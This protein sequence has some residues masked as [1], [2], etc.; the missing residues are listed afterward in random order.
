[1]LIFLIAVLSLVYLLVYKPA[2]R[3]AAGLN[4]PLATAWTALARDPYGALGEDA[5]GRIDLGTLRM[6]LSQAE[7]LSAGFVALSNQLQRRIEPSPEVKARMLSPFQLVAY[8]NERQLKLEQLQAHART[9]QVGLAQTTVSNWFPEHSA[10]LRNPAL[11]WGQLWM[12]DALAR[13]A[14]AC[15]VSEIRQISP[16][17]VVSRV[18]TNDP[19]VSIEEVPIAAEMIGSASS[20]AHFL[21]SLPLKDEEIAAAGL[22][23]GGTNKPVLFIEKVLV[24]KHSPEQADQVNLELK[25]RGVLLRQLPASAP[26]SVPSS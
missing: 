6:R 16:G 20:I 2:S 3:R 18:F 23:S 24:R 14:V 11:L 9:F 5:S 10:E 21:R 13:L 17:A 1:M 26:F 4:E 15:R 25:V 19:P 12:T 7:R 8:Q 22:P